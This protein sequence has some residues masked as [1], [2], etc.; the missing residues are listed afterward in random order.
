L[1]V[2]LPLSAQDLAPRAYVSTPGRSSALTLT[3]S[4][5]DGG[6]NFNGAMPITNATG[7]FSVSIFS[8]YHSLVFSAGPPT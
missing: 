2:G 1:F 6:V 8:G 5:Y 3:Y 4:F 7:T